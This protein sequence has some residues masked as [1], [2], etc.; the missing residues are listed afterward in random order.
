MKTLPTKFTKNDFEFE[1][2]QRTGDVAIYRKK[3]PNHSQWTFETIIVGRHNG[4]TLGGNHIAPAET[5]PSSEAWGA[6][7]W[8]YQ[9]KACAFAKMD[10]LLHE[11]A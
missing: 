5:Y 3:R 10:S 4:F 8:T 1:Q 11:R 9:D 6:S 7:G 2:L